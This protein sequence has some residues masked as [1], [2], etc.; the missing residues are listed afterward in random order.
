VDVTVVRR[1]GNC[2]VECLGGGS[3][4][5]FWNLQ[6]HS[7]AFFFSLFTS[8]SFTPRR[9]SEG[10]AV[11]LA[12]RRVVGLVADG[13]PWWRQLHRTASHLISQGAGSLTCADHETTL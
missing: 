11:C 12:G 4:L 8:F 13:L 5:L 2:P 9:G 1:L 3:S 10:S 6:Q 7:D